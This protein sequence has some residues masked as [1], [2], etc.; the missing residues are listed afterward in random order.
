MKAFWRP[1]T[2]LLKT[3]NIAFEGLGGPGAYPH[4]LPTHGGTG[5]FCILLPTPH[6]PNPSYSMG[7]WE[8]RN[9]GKGPKVT[10]RHAET[11]TEHRHTQT[12]AAEHRHRITHRHTQTCRQAGRQTQTQ[13]NK[14]QTKTKRKN[15]RNKQTASEQSSKI[16]Q[17]GKSEGSSP[18]SALLAGC[19]WIWLA[20]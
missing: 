4:S 1:L 14:E 9:Q 19:R 17:K 7:C 2:C 6:P 10:Q 16:T 5:R 8:E 18:P 13:T 12:H 11:Q 20:G 3:F 15:E